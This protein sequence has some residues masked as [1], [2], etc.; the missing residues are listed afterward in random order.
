MT[1]PQCPEVA[2]IACVGLPDDVYGEI[3]AA[4]AV[5]KE[6]STLTLESLGEWAK[7]RMAAYKI[8]RKLK[9]VSSLPRN[10]MGKV[11]VDHV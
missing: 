4:V 8:P 6:G 9:L 7:Q 11:F 1:S 5:T 3:V 10:A 2:E